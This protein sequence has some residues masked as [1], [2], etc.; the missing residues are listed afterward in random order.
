MRDD[1][2]KVF[3]NSETRWDKTQAHYNFN[4]EPQT[5]KLRRTGAEMGQH[6]EVFIDTIC[7]YIPFSYLPDKLKRSSNNIQDIWN[8]VYEAYNVKLSNASILDWGTMKQLTG[9]TPFCFYERLM[10]HIRKN[11]V[12]EDFTALGF[13]SPH[14]VQ[15]GC[16]PLAQLH[17][18][19]THCCSKEGV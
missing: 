18:F 3:L 13:T 7:R 12:K 19:Q 17:R 15:S 9:E 14:D 10:D 6:L 11:L 2:F 4:D 5:S 8:L 16:G 1:Y